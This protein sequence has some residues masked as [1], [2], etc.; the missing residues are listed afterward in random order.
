MKRRLKIS[1]RNNEDR[2]HCLTASELF[3]HTIRSKNLQYHV[4]KQ[5]ISI[6]NHQP[7][8]RKPDEGR[9][10]AVVGDVYR[11][12]ATSEDTNGKYSMWEA[13]VPPGGGPP[14]AVDCSSTIRRGDQGA[15]RVITMRHRKP[16]L[17]EKTCVV[18][19]RPFSWRRKWEKV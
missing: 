19:G 5:D 9:T 6:M 11:F 17:P 10:I 16:N 4:L 2:Q 3:Q 14:Q 7:T 13:I 8:I 15:A 12:M 1:D 18:C